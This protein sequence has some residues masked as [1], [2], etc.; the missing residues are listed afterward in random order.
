MSHNTD[1][2]VTD[3]TVLITGA[4]SGIGAHL[5]RA[6]ATRGANVVLCA[7]RRENLDLLAG[8][9]GENALAASMDVTSPNSVRQAFVAA[10]QAFGPVTVLI[11]NAGVARNGQ[12]WEQAEGDWDFV[13]DVN[14]KAVWRVAKEAAARMLAHK[15]NGS[16]INISSILGVG[17]QPGYTLYATSKA[18]VIQMTRTMALELFSKG[19]RVNAL[20]PGYFQTEM[21]D[22]FFSSTKGQAYVRK[23]PPGRLGQLEE[24]VGPALL[25]A[26]EAGSFINGVALPV[27][28]GHHVRLI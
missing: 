18:G 20:C 27:D 4:S 5:A 28:G 9:I 11:N 1:F 17:T 3:K 22:A 19:I 16:I 7:R 8:E 10:E 21:N 14:L 23:T 12:S 25:L 13:M 6:F 24:L 2:D 15:M 26:S